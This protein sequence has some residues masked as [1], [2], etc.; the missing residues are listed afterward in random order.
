MQPALH[1]LRYADAA[2]DRNATAGADASGYSSGNDDSYVDTK[3]GGDFADANATPRDVP[4][5]ANARAF[6]FVCEPWTGRSRFVRLGRDDRIFCVDL[7][8]L[9]QLIATA[10]R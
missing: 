1:P 3:A 4:A 9:P 10:N 2:T 8:S 6:R 7:A 5:D